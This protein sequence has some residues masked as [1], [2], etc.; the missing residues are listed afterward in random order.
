MISL[1]LFFLHILNKAH[2]RRYDG[3]A[4]LRYYTAEGLCLKEKR[5]S[6]RSG[7]WT[8]SGSKYFPNAAPKALVVFFHGVGA[9]R[10]AY[11]LEISELVKQGYLVY[12]YDNTG[13]VESQGPK[14]YGVGNVNKDIEAFYSWLEKDQDSYGL[15]RFSVGHSWGGYSALLSSKSAYKVEKIVSI[16]GFM[17]PSDEY[18]YYIRQKLF[19]HLKP[20]IHVALKLQL[21]RNGDYD[22]A[23]SLEKSNASVLYIQGDE[24]K[25]VTL[26]AGYNSIKKRFGSNRRFSFLLVQGKK[27]NPYMTKKA[28]K[29]LDELGSKGILS[30]KGDTSLMM[31]IKAATEEDPVVTKAIFDFLKN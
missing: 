30:P 19:H 12:A 5:F 23:K 26:D 15:A 10:A 31:D 2:G 4:S 16:S 20:L 21:G 18:V 29:Y 24:D 6:F 25:T 28:E 9:G 3:F 11:L 22:A 1:L 7:K 14:I 13:C 27:H 8:L 17:K